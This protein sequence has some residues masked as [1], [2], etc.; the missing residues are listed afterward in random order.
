MGR[1]QH[2]A[3]GLVHHG[4]HL[5]RLALLAFEHIDLGVGRL[6]RAARAV[7]PLHQPGGGSLAS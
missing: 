1:L 7:G 3:A 4:S 5:L 2:A 6:A